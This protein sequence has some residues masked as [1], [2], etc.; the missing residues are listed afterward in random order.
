MFSFVDQSGSN[1]PGLD[2]HSVADMADGPVREAMW[3]MCV[4]QKT[5]SAGQVQN[6]NF[7]GLMII[8][9]LSL[10]IITL[11]LILEPCVRRLRMWRGSASGRLRQLSLDMDGKYRLLQAALEGQGVGPWRKGGRKKDSEIPVTDGKQMPQ[12]SILDR[13]DLPPL[14]QLKAEV[15]DKNETER[16]SP[17]P[18]DGN[19]SK[20]HGLVGITPRSSS[21]T[22]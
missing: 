4:N 3:N 1:T 16:M 11:A 14:Y 13:D 15:K 12:L 2:V 22:I 19:M 6:L 9:C 10:F 20:Q 5:S 8:T 7:V 18:L 21:A 17:R